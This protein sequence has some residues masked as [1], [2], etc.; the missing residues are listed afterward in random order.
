MMTLAVGGDALC[1]GAPLTGRPSPLATALAVTVPVGD[2]A[3]AAPLKLAA[4]IDAGY[5]MVAALVDAVVGVPE[6]ATVTTVGLVRVAAPT[7][8]PA[9]NPVILVKFAAVTVVA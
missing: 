5:A 2:I 9:D 8:N 1:V 6:M 4:G 3:A 7:L